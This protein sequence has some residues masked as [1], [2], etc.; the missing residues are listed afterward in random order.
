[1]KR[2]NWNHQNY[3]NSL[4]ANIV[5]NPVSHACIDKWIE[6]LNQ[7]IMRKLQI[8]QLGMTIWQRKKQ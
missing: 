5:S 4:K 2:E 3:L 7:G 6:Q 1:M 8:D